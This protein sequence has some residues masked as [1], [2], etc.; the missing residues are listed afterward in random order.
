MLGKHPVRHCSN[1]Q[2][3]IALSS[4]ESEYYGIVKGAA[5][6]LGLQALLADWGLQVG[7]VVSSDSSA[8]R[9][10][11]SR[12]GLGKTRHVQTRYLWIQDR[13]ANGDFRVA[14]I[15]TEDNVVDV[16]TKPVPAE[17]L[18]R[19]VSTLCQESRDGRASEALCVQ[20]SL[21]VPKGSC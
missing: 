2:S 15:R 4:G 17:T 8:A 10:I 18:A 11:A 19:R 9:S 14:R 20:G 6:G 5:A 3:T 12:K 7:V 21:S 16:L 1:L 13:L